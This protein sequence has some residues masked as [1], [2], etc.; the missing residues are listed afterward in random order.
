MSARKRILFILHMPPPVHGAAVVGKMIHDS[1]LIN[2]AFDCRFIN[3]ATASGLEDIGKF[4]FNKISRFTTLLK[5]IRRE[6][7][8]FSPD[9]IY[10]TP[11]SA[12]AAFYKDWL[13]VWM[14]KNTGIPVVAHF[15]NKG[16]SRNSS[17]AIKRTLYKIFFRNLNV[18]LLS[19]RLF[20]DIER[21]ADPT[22]VHFCPNGIV[23]NSSQQTDR[24]ENTPPRILFISN[25]LVSKGILTLLDSLRS[26]ND[27]GYDFRCDIAGAETF[28][29]DRKRLDEEIKAR[30]LDNKVIYHGAVYGNE[31]ERLLD[32][33]D[34]LVFPTFYECEAFPLVCLEAMSHRLPVIST[35][36]G[37]IPDIVS[38]DLTGFICQ[39]QNSVQFADKIITLLSDNGLRKNMGQAGRERFENQFTIS[40]FEQKMHDTLHNIS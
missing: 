7:K 13:T 33:S 30:K 28:E 17:N 15:H 40:A 25:L 29:I 24:K 6:I 11:N 8:S 20:S 22:R 12:G 31:K 2:V 18:I 26:V 37:G 3:L 14:L 27:R 39:K 35:N 19:R 34:M 5:N 23:D 9:L 16:V 36:E 38:D 21:Y 4:R 32:N 1:R 10:I